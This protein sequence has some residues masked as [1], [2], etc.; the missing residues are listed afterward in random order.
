MAGPDAFD[1]RDGR[2]VQAVPGDPDAASRVLLREDRIEVRLEVR[3][4]PSAGDEHEGGREERVAVPHPGRED[5][6]PEP[7]A[8]DERRDGGCEG[9]GAEDRE[10]PEHRLPGHGG[11][12]TRWALRTFGPHAG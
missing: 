2:V 1:D 5:V 9:E 12:R 8:V 10:D 7:V 4:S 6:P 11:M 3:V